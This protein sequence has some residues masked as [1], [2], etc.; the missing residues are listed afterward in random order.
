MI[1]ENCILWKKAALEAEDL[2]DLFDG[3]HV[4]HQDPD[5]SKRLLRCKEC[6]QLYVYEYTGSGDP[7]DSSLQILYIPVKKVGNLIEASANGLPRLEVLWPAGQ[8]KPT[9]TW[10]R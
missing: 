3:V 2:Y 5:T 6:E 7:Q 4:F 10:V 1:P 9:V 8:E